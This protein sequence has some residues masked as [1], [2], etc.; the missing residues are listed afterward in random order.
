MKSKTSKLLAGTSCV[1]AFMLMS[2]V[3]VADWPELRGPNRDGTASDRNLPERWSPSGENLAWRSPYGSRSGP[4][5]F[6]DRLYLQ[7]EVGQGDDAMER[8]LA[9]DANT[10]KLVWEHRFPVYLTDVPAHRTGWA[11]PAVDPETGHVY[12]LG[13]N[14]HFSSF[15][16]DGKLRWERS[17]VEEYGF[18]TTHGGRTVSPVI[19]GD[20]VIIN[21]L[22]VGWGSLGRGGNRWFAFNKTTGHTAWVSS[23]QKRH[24]DTNMSPPAIT[25][26]DGTRLLIVGGSDGA[27]HAMKV[28]TGEPVWE[29]DVSKRAILTGAVLKGT[30]AYLTHSEENLGTNEMGM[31][32]AIDASKTGAL[33]AADK[34]WVVHGFLVGFASPVIDGERLYA[35]DNGAVLA[36][37]SLADGRKLWDRILGT[38]QKS[39]P[40]LA[41]GKLYVGTENGKF[42][43][44][45]PSATGVEV[46]DEDWLGSEAEPEPII[47]N[48]AVSNGRVYVTSLEATYAIGTNA[49]KAPPARLEP[50]TPEP[51][52]TDPPA[53]VQVFPYEVLLKPG[54]QATFTVRLFDAKGRF[55]REE[56]NATW[57]LDAL[58]GTIAKGVYTAPARSDAGTIKATVGSV[59]GE[60]R[61]RVI[62]PPPFTYDFD[63]WEGETPPEYWINTQNKFF[64]RELDGNRV[65]VRVPDATPQRRTR[66]FVGASTWSDLTVEADVRSTERR[67][68]LSDV[69]LF[70]Q[71]YG[72]VLFGNA[73]KVELQPWQAAAAR[74]VSVPFAWKPET[75]YHVKLRVQ[76][77]PGGVT[78]AQGKIWPRGEQE[79]AA[80][81][82]EKKD[83]IG[84]RAGS[85]GLY[86]DPNSE[87]YFDN[88]KVTVNR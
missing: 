64:V 57:A 42:Y 11:S 53:V 20:L 31:I 83:H 75:W 32:A 86:A 22:N 73:Q 84:H 23:P 2:V 69:G 36:A 51:P 81:T 58:G 62:A 41:D 34:K 78:L 3:L 10:G 33:G 12:A 88:V 16:R 9:L 26:I 7:T 25:T 38:I 18:I 59:A 21:S 74:S 14:G 29:L 79:P 45:R 82:V 67:R 48:P 85:P 17:L 15:T 46:L 70:N 24:F 50:R 30:T 87:V 63:A 66:L 28:N 65:L 40:V 61:V 47:G 4:V 35:V 37:F 56:A 60:A 6:G 76:N 77:L 49:P 72:L 1:T 68:T 13:V 19:V 43:I 5:V 71:R 54:E 55:I 52:S 8:V 39:S 27:W 44:L 80:W